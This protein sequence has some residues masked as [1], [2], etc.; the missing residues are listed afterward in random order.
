[1]AWK[2]YKSSSVTIRTSEVLKKKFNIAIGTLNM[3][4]IIET[5][6]HNV[7]RDFERDF[8]VIPVNPNNAEKIELLKK[9]LWVVV[10]EKQLERML[11]NNAP[12]YWTGYV[13]SEEKQNIRDHIADKTD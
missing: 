2:I 9:T 8:W 1:M 4:Q 6:M 12:R 3:S 5:Y 13:S 11:Q 7:V 10:N